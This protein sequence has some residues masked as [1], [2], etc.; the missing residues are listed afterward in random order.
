MDIW[1]EFINHYKEFIEYDGSGIRITITN[2]GLLA[3]KSYKTLE[4]Y[5]RFFIGLSPLKLVL[6]V[7][8]YVTKVPQLKNSEIGKIKKMWMNENV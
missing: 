7:S 4:D 5:T 1:Y 2:D 8:K 6:P 3:A